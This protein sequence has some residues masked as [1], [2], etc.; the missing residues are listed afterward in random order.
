MLAA[1]RIDALF[2][3]N[4]VQ[5]NVTANLLKYNELGKLFNKKRRHGHLSQKQYSERKIWAAKSWQPWYS[6]S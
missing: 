1:W 6:K 4:D 3:R 5:F 2:R